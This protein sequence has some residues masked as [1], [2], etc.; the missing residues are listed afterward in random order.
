M[1]QE[2]GRS[3]IE[4]IGVLAIMGALT[5]VAFMLIRDATGSQKQR[6][7][8]DEVTT[9]MS[10]VR[11]I[12]NGYD[13]FSLMDGDRIL[14]MMHKEQNPYGGTYGLVVDPSNPRQFV[15]S[16]NGLDQTDCEALSMT[17]W[18]DSVGYRLS[19]KKQ[20][21]AVGSCDGD[22]GTNSVQITFGE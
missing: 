2:S 20:S 3:M 22:N 13:D 9:I 17:A 4:M 8:T 16:I 1:N 18:T 19:D 15:V 14:S 6:E 10:K 5:G 21:G 12:H 7:V 11:E